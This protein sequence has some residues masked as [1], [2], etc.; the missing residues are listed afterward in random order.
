M[1]IRAFGQ[2]LHLSI[3]TLVVL[4]SI[5]LFGCFIAGEYLVGHESVWQLVKEAWIRGLLFS[6]IMVLNL[7]AF[8]LYSSRQRARVGGIAIRV[9][10]AIC[11]GIA[12][13]AA[14]FYVIPSL[15]VDRG[16][17]AIT[18]VFTL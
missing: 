11:A 10:A 7:L 16:V 2:H 4:E 9:I 15:R 3:A 1:R 18:I 8:G 12:V 5:L 14:F 13:M 17:I 6:V